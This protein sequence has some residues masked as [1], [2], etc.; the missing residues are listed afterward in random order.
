MYYE[1]LALFYVLFFLFCIHPHHLSME[2]ECIHYSCTSSPE[3]YS[4]K[5]TKKRFM[6]FSV[7]CDTLSL[8]SF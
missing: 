5:Q 2:Q 7:P 1:L 3:Q 6:H 4:L 8:K